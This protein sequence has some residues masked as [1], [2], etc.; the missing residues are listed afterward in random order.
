MSSLSGVRVLDLSRVF[1]GPWAGQMLA[2]FGADVVK[3]ERPGRG[4]DVRQQGLRAKDAEGK[5]TREIDGRMY[6][7][8]TPIHADVALIRAD[9]DPRVSGTP[10]VALS[11][12]ILDYQDETLAALGFDGFLAKPIQVAELLA[13]VS[14]IGQAAEAA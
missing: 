10:V 11:A 3:V 4:D 8:E 2:D 14:L 6:V 1:S 9:P 5:E 7:F 13:L 12:D